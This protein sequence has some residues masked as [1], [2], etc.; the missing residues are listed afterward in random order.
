MVKMSVQQRGSFQKARN[1]L[2]FCLKV[3]QRIIYF[4]R[5]QTSEKPKK[6]TI[7]VPSAIVYFLLLKQS[8]C[9]WVLYKWKS[10]QR[11]K[12]KV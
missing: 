5:Y 9:G 6:N 7:N 2:N 1:E 12:Q 8:T 3:R 4:E 11:W 10:L